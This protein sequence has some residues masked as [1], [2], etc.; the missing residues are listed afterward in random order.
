MA[1]LQTGGRHHKDDPTKRGYHCD[2]RN[3][4][5]ASLQLEAL[6]KSVLIWTSARLYFPKKAFILDWLCWRLGARERRKCY[7]SAI[8]LF[9][10]PAQS[11]VKGKRPSKRPAGT[12]CCVAL[13]WTHETCGGKESRWTCGEFQFLSYGQAII[14]IYILSTSGVLIG[15]W[16]QKSKQRSS[17]IQCIMR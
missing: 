16:T 7:S 6:P 2:A 5:C 17:E 12:W 10:K 11:L 13:S 4:R 1:R 8:L 3:L 14:Y 15:G 9:P